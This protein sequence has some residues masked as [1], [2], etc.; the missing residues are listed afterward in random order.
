[1]RDE[2]GVA[3]ALDERFAEIDRGDGLAGQCVLHD[4]PL[5]EDC[6]PAD[7]RE[8][9]ERIQDARCIGCDLQ[10]CADFP[11][12]RRLLHDVARDAPRRER[13]GR[14]QSAETAADDEQ[15]HFAWRDH[16]ADWGRVRGSSSIGPI[17]TQVD[18]TQNGI[19]RIGQSS[20]RAG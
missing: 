9:A 16:S 7:L 11:E 4:Q 19:A 2:I 8:R 6:G 17:V 13:E 3:V 5:G 1:V 10:P 12:L 15:R 14:G 18:R 20:E